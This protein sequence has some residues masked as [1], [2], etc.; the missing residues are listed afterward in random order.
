[1]LIVNILQRQS[2]L[3]QGLRQ[4]TDPTQHNTTLR[5]LH[6][7]SKIKQT[8]YP[9]GA[10]LVVNA[11]MIPRQIIILYKIINLIYGM[12]CKTDT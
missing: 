5:L 8:V 11:S 12:Q 9:I 10:Y 2:L 6:K 4:N 1:M 7:T 3:F